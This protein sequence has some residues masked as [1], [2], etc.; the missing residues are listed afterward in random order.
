[1]DSSRNR[2]LKLKEYL[3]SENIIVNIGKNKA[4]GNKGFFAGRDNGYR[5]DVAKN[6]SE[7]GVF[8]VLLHEFAHYIHYKYDTGLQNLDFVFGQYTENIKDELIRITV[9]D[10]PKEFASSLFETKKRLSEEIKAYIKE[11]KTEYPNFKSSERNKYLENNLSIIQK[12]LLHYDRIKIFNKI[13]S[14]NNSED[15]SNLSKAQTAYILLKSKQRSI[16]RI[17]KK[18]NHLNKYY[19]N[20]SELFARFFT[21]YY[22]DPQ[23]AEKLAPIATEKLKNSNLTYVKKIDKILN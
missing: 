12:Y 5:I 23:K 20:P 11:I 9:N 16:K 17:N 3:L 8:S 21:L 14:V 15:L 4:R 6:L 22:T 18:I 13:H 1:M 10:I 19:N 7:N 2:I